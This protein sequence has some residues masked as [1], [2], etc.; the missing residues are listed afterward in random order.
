MSKSVVL[1][2]IR[3]NEEPQLGNYFGA[4]LPIIDMAK[5]N[6]SKYQINL[7]VPDL[8]S[9]TTEIQ[10][11]RLYDQTINTLKKFYIKIKVRP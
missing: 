5:K 1:T 9:F 6:S 4:M 3:S 11:D 2:G 10:Y 8:H 7:F